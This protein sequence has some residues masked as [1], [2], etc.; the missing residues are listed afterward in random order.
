MI[1]SRSRTLVLLA[2]SCGIVPAL[3]RGDAR[4]GEARVVGVANGPALLEVLGAHAEITLAP[5]SRDIGALVALPPGRRASDLGLAPVVQGVGRLRGSRD[6]LLSFARQ[7]PSLRLEVAPPLHL[8]ND[9]IGAYSGARFS[10]VRGATGAGVYVGVADTGLDVAHPDMLDAS[11]KSRVAWM[12]DL[13]LQ[14]VSVIDPAWKYRAIEEVFSVRNG[15]GK[16]AAGAVLTGAD[17]DRQIQGKKGLPRDDIGHGTHVA[18]IAAGTGAGGPYGGVAPAAKL[19]IVRVTR[20]GSDGIETDDLVRAVQ[21]MFDRA[22]ADGVPLVANLSLGSDFGSH[23][24]NM[25]WEQTIASFVGPDKPGHAIVAAAGNSGSIA[26]A[27]IHQSVRVSPRK[28]LYVPVRTHGAESGSVQIWVALR[29]NADLRIGLEGPDGEWIAPVSEGSKQGKKGQGYDAGVVFG[30][31][32]GQDSQIPPGSRGAIV[33]WSG[34]WPAG[35]Y[36]VTLE[37]EGTADLYLQGGGDASL[38]GAKPASFLDGVR[39]GTINLPASHPNVIGVGCTVNRPKWTSIARQEVAV[40]VPVLDARGGFPAYG[41][42]PRV[43]VEGE[44]CWFSSA[45]PTVAGVA[46]PEI[47][48]PGGVVVSTMSKQAAPGNPGSVFS[49]QNCPPTPEGQPDARCLQVDETHAI[50]VGTSMASPIVAGVVAL[51]VQRDPTLTQGR[52]TALLQG[53]AHRTRG[54]APFADQAGPG[55]VD[56]WGSLLALDALRAPI[57]VA[58]DPEASWIATSANYVAAAGE[59]P[60]TVY[61]ETRTADGRPADFRDPTRLSPVVVVAGKSVDPLPTLTR[62]G[63]G[64]FVYQFTPAPGNGGRSATV[65]ARFDGRPIGA[66]K[67][68]PIAMDTWTASYAPAVRGGCAAGAGSVQR[69]WI[70]VGCAGALLLARRGRRRPR[71]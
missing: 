65:G 42:Q 50:S 26:D 18:G 7:H 4:A 35:S 24:G 32:A 36:P 21:F 71:G 67:T 13:S 61:V 38:G 9:R 53:G 8:L 59:T 2:L 23:D 11:G 40:R 33:V 52:I 14:P 46:K 57:D 41:A 54:P 66:W 44:V 55:E 17:I 19:V 39:E 70:L 51:L 1:R 27:P 45:G 31:A 58:P 12:L 34:S 63:P 69:A 22:D 62:R 25:L 64:V 49:S 20:D 48:A 68:I 29:K 10:Q 37:G 60:F 56:A 6:R 43:L 15:E 28:R 47:T 16:L 3:L 30:Q 5:A